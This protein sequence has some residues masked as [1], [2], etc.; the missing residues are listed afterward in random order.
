MEGESVKIT[1]SR[2]NV[3]ED[4]IWSCKNAALVFS[5]RWE[6]KKKSTFDLVVVLIVEA[7]FK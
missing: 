3:D 7:A 2:R 5:Y 4:Y 6:K 1:V